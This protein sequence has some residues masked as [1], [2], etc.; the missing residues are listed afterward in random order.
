MPGVFTGRYKDSNNLTWATFTTIRR[1]DPDSTKKP[2]TICNH[3]NFERSVVSKYIRLSA[4]HHN[5]KFYFCAAPTRYSHYGDIRGALVL[6]ELA[7]ESPIWLTARTTKENQL[8]AN[9]L[10]DV[11]KIHLSEP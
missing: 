5:R 2:E 3:V 11:A 6:F 9:R 8:R 1:F 10:L 7:G 4:E